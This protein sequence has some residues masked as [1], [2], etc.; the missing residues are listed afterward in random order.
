VSASQ[1]LEPSVK[2]IVQVRLIGQSQEDLQHAIAW[3]SLAQTLTNEAIASVA[4]GLRP[5][6]L[7]IQASRGPG[8][9]GD[10]LAYGTIAAD[11]QPVVMPELGIVARPA[12][13]EHN[14]QLKESHL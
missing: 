4:D 11:N 9:K 7:H 8:R 10:Y 14:N 5:L 12:P 3:L 6:E 13:F 2:R 1:D